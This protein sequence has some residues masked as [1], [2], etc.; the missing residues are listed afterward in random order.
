MSVS[1]K[2]IDSDSA[3]SCSKSLMLNTE[4]YTTSA[5]LKIFA[6][7]INK[8]N[9]SKFVSSALDTTPLKMAL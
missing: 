1:L 7:M 4:K 8:V 9:P 2:S 5:K 3:S 6:L